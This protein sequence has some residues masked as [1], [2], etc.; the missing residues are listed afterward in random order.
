MRPPRALPA[1]HFER[2]DVTIYMRDGALGGFAFQGFYKGGRLAQPVRSS[3]HDLNTLSSRSSERG[4]PG[5]HISN[6]IGPNCGSHLARRRQTS[7][8]GVNISCTQSLHN[9]PTDGF[10]DSGGGLVHCE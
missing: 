10:L 7:C 2:D 3:Q 6:E 8:F 5:S 9:R 4:L 1:A